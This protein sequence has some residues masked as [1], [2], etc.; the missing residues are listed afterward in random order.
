MLILKNSMIFRKLLNTELPINHK[1][2]E[3]PKMD[4]KLN[5]NMCITDILGANFNIFSKFPNLLYQ[6]D[7]RRSKST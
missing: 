5:Q 1:D 3:L 6:N 7:Q 4:Q 2:E